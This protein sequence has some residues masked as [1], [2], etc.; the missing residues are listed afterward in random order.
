MEKCHRQRRNEVERKVER[1]SRQ[2]ST[3]H[4]AKAGAEVGEMTPAG[5]GGILWRQNEGR[6]VQEVGRLPPKYGYGAANLHM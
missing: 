1:E 2:W 4:F 3:T 5:R 6:L